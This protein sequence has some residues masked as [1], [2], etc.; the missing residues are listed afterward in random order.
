V[1]DTDVKLKKLTADSFKK[2]GNIIAIPP[3]VEPTI[4]TG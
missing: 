2:H 4:S 3:D 1:K